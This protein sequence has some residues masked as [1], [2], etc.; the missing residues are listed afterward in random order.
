MAIDTLYAREIYVDSLYGGDVAGGAKGGDTAGGGGGTVE[1]LT[2]HN[3]K[4][5][6]L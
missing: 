3:D 4:P 2:Y 6:Y 1:G 5:P